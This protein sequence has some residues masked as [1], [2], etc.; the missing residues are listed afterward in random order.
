MEEVFKMANTQTKKLSS[1]AFTFKEIKISIMRH[2][3]YLS[4]YHELKCLTVSC[5]RKRGNRII[6]ILFKHFCSEYKLIEKNL[7]ISFKI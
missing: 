6:Q 3:L 2:N 5:S 7:T 4:K 1:I